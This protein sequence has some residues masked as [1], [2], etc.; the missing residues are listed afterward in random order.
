MTDQDLPWCDSTK[1]KFSSQADAELLADVRAIA[2]EEGRQFQA[3]L[4]E[5]LSEWV[6]RKRGL[7]PRPEV[8][9]HLKASM[10]P[11]RELY[12]RLAE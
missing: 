2:H 1:Q 12:R 9:A 6:D 4:D 10:A 7:R 11:N 3:V 8:L 5:A